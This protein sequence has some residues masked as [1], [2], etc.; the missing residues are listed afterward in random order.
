MEGLYFWI[1]LCP[2]QIPMLGGGTISGATLKNFLTIPEQHQ[3]QL[4]NPLEKTQGGFSVTPID[5][6]E[7]K[8][9]K[10][11]ADAIT[12]REVPSW[13]SKDQPLTQM[14]QVACLYNVTEFLTLLGMIGYYQHSVPGFTT[15]D[16]PLTWLTQK[17]TM[18]ALDHGV[19]IAL[20]GLK[21]FMVTIPIMIYPGLLLPSF[22]N[23]DS[24]GIAMG[25]VLYQCVGAGKQVVG[26]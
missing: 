16:W 26:H 4:L 7:T 8:T 23:T 10:V 2:S 19:Q 20:D 3:A 14:T 18:W 13:A 17:F 1:E 9:S 24:S 25:A 6:N 5:R 15:R 11:Q 12:G 21:I 22:L